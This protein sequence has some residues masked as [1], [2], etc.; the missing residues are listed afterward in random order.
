MGDHS[1]HIF[2]SMEESDENV[3]EEEAEEEPEEEQEEEDDSGSSE[4]EGEVEDD[5]SDLWRLLRQ[6]VWEDLKELYLKEVQRFLE[7][8][9]TQTYVANAAF[10]AC[11]TTC[12]HQGSTLVDPP[13]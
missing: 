3:E 13:F 8:E 9:K 12:F 7:R 4:E 5:E 10:N 1:T 11:A 6:E 2:G